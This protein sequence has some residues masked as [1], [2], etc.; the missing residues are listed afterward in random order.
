MPGILDLV[1]QAL[2]ENGAQAISQQLGANPQQTQS[3]IAAAL[4]T[5]I[6]GLAHHSA[7]GDNAT[8]LTNTLQNHDTG[9]LG[10]VAG[11][12]QSG[13]AQTMGGNLL[14][15]FLGQHRDNAAGAIAGSSGLD[16]G[17]A[18]QLLAM[19]APIVMSAVA[20]HSQQ[21][22]GLNAGNLVSMLQGEHQNVTS[23]QPDLAGLAGQLFGGNTNSMMGALEKGLGGLLGGR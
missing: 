20:Q 10:D 16:T 7:Q 15:H 19:L 17:Q 18:G 4:P 11:F 12:L 9:I 3:A 14:G 1:T 23:S 8:N 21:Q 13:N 5:L 2:G 6:A 22:G